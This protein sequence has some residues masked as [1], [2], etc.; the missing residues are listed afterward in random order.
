MKKAAAAGTLYREQPFVIGVDSSEIDRVYELGETVLVQGIIEAFFGCFLVLQDCHGN[1]S[2]IIP[3]FVGRL[4]QSPLVAL[5]IQLDN[6]TI[7]QHTLNLFLLRDLNASGVRLPFTLLHS[8]GS[9]T[10]H[11]R[12]EKRFRHKP[13]IPYESKTG[14]PDLYDP[15]GRSCWCIWYLSICVQRC[16]TFKCGSVDPHCRTY[17]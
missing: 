14:P 6:L 4:H 11:R 12:F 17:A 5:K 8:F 3:I 15:T 16:Y 13:I 9:K 2:A 10:L 1:T 7:F